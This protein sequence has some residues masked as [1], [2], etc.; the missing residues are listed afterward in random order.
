M[1]LATI[2]DCWLDRRRA[3]RTRERLADVAGRCTPCGLQ[4]GLQVRQWVFRFVPV[5]ARFA[6]LAG[7]KTPRPRLLDASMYTWR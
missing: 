3:V 4:F 2:Q 6:I 7:S 1:A 5:I